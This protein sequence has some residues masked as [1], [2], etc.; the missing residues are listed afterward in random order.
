MRFHVEADNRVI[1]ES[2]DNPAPFGLIF[3]RHVDEIFLFVARRVPRQDAPDLTADVFER[4]LRSRHRY[5]PSY[6][7]ALPW[8]RGIA[9]NVI[10]EYLKSRHRSQR[11]Q[12]QEIPLGFE[13]DRKSVV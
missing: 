9:R 3:D 13:T 2:W 12:G 11:T 1:E 4:A 8:L 7:S 5:D 10:G 6:R